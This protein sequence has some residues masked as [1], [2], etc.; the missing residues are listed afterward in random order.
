M[1]HMIFA[2][3]DSRED[4]QAAVDEVGERFPDCS[5]RTSIIMH[6][7]H[8]DDDEVQPSETDSRAGMAFGTAA[9]AAGGAL[10][11]GIITGG[12]G[13]PLAIIGIGALQGSI[14][15]GVAGAISGTTEPDHRMQKLAEQ[16]KEGKVLVSANVRGLECGRQIEEIFE[17]YDAVLEERDLL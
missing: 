3:F 10:L 12:L 16:L 6:Q 14:L 4:A 15:G 8:L 5:N 1:Q 17:D 11:T 9:G 13:L 7:D 2:L